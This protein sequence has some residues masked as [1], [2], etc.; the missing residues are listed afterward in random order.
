MLMRCSCEGDSELQSEWCA[1]QRSGNGFLLMLA[2]CC[3]C[4]HSESWSTGETNHSGRS[5]GRR[6]LFLCILV[7]K[8]KSMFTD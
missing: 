2:G 1:G 3:I 7:F 4:W 6:V 8:R 5:F